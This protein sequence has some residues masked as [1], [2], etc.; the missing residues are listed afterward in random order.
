MKE[1][2]GELNLTLIVVT[3]V[4]LLST[5]FFT[6]IWPR[7]HHN[8]DRNSRCDAAICN[9]DR[10]GSGGC[11]NFKNGGIEC[12]YYSKYGKLSD[13]RGNYDLIV[14]AWKG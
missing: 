3:I 11:T 10:D 4:A 7:I 9:C 1:A 8:L 6:V 14:C 13:E 5:L 12:K 2:T